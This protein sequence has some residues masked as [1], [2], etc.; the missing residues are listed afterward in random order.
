[1]NNKTEIAC[2][3]FCHNEETKVFYKFINPLPFYSF[4]VLRKK[5]FT[6]EQ[7]ILVQ[8]DIE[9]SEDLL[10]FK[11]SGTHC[12]LELELCNWIKAIEMMKS[13]F[14]FDDNK[15]IGIG[16]RFVSDKL[17]MMFD[18]ISDLTSAIQSMDFCQERAF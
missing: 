16:D 11:E 6:A 3:E 5:G 12:D 13:T 14:G 4:L 1:M 10:W 18:S 15:V 9:L 17:M 8:N 2:G 7:I